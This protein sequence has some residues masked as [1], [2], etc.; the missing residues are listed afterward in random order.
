[1]V[2]SV[3][4]PPVV[5]ADDVAGPQQHRGVVGERRRAEGAGRRHVDGE[6]RRRGAEVERRAECDAAALDQLHRAAADRMV[7]AGHAADDVE[8]HVAVGDRPGRR[9]PVEPPTVIVSPIRSRRSA[10]AVNSSVVCPAASGTA[11]VEVDQRILRVAGH[12][13]QRHRRPVARPDLDREAVAVDA[14]VA[15]REGRRRRAATAVGGPLIR[16]TVLAGSSTTPPGISSAATTVTLSRT[17][18]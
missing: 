6:G 4:T 15:G 3:V 2:T 12:R 11:G 10:G 9:R 7:G 1:M 14:A 18:S 5:D 8:G 16:M 17:A 13:G